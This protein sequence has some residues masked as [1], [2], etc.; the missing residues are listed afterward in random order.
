MPP[1]GAAAVGNNIFPGNANL[2]PVLGSPT[3]RGALTSVLGADYA[4]HLHRALHVSGGGDQGFHKDTPEGGGPARHMR[5][6]WCMVM[7]YPAGSTLEMGPTCI[8]PGGQYFGIDPEKAREMAESMG[9]VQG[10]CEFK[11]TTPLAHGTAILIHF[12]MYHRGSRRLTDPD[13][14]ERWAAS[15]AGPAPLRPMVKFQFYSVSEPTRPNWD[16]GPLGETGAKADWG[17]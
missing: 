8:L 16:A 13:R 2:G 9:A 6:R 17:R 11:V 10:L 3:V 14:T 15:R 7:Y 12:H 5:P 4:L 1:A